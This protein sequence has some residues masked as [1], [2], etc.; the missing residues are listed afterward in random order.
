MR[1]VEFFVFTCEKTLT[2]SPGPNTGHCYD[3]IDTRKS[4]KSITIL[5]VGRGSAQKCPGTGSL[6]KTGMFC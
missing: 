3:I 6:A 2:P 1:N 5:S 4:E